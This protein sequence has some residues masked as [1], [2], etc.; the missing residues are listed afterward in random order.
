MANYK[1]FDFIKMFYDIKQVCMS[2]DVCGT[3][4]YGDCLVGYARECIG[5][6]KKQDTDTLKG[7][8]N[9]IPT[10][11]TKGGYDKNLAMDAIAHTLQQC[12]S[13]KDFHKLDCLVNVIRNCYEVIVFGE[14]KEYPGSTFMYLN[15]I[16][17]DNPEIANYI[18]EIYKE[19]KNPVDELINHE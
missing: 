8:F 16:S 13:C 18:S 7:A 14:E 3:C 2:E 9:K 6:A 11:D 17:Q 5:E 10:L 15:K 4:T 1:E 12:K 19:H